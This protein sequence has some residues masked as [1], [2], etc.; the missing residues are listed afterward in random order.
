MGGLT[1]KGDAGLPDSTGSWFNAPELSFEFLS[2]S[3]N[4]EKI[5]RILRHFLLIDTNFAKLIFAIIM[6]QFLDF[7]FY[8]FCP[9]QILSLYIEEHG[10]I[11]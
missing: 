1:A 3:G 5:L 8:F 9:E 7:H 11:V 6:S 4:Q 2:F 10:D